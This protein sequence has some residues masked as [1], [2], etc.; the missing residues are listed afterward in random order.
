ML[1]DGKKVSAQRLI[2]SLQGRLTVCSLL[3]ALYAIRVSFTILID[4][5]HT[6]KVPALLLYSWQPEVKLLLNTPG[7]GKGPKFSEL[8]SM[9]FSS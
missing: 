2:R 6:K 3:V 7:V 1:N 9:E 4:A 5:V 8:S